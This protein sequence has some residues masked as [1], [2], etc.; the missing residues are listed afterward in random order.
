M[1]R[2]QLTHP[3]LGQNGEGTGTVWKCH[4][5]TLVKEERECGEYCDD[6]KVK[7]VLQ[8]NPSASAHDV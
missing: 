2:I 6:I 5:Q 3:K 8:A 7:I 1:H 4:M